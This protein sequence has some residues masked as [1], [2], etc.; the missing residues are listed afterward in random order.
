MTEAVRTIAV[1][2]V[3][4]DGLVLVGRRSPTAVEWPDFDEFPGGKVEPGETTAEAATRECLE[5]SGIAVR[6]GERSFGV[7]STPARPH[8]VVSFH[9]AT[10]VD[11]AATPTPPFAWIPLSQLPKLNFPPANAPVLAMLQRDQG[12]S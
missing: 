3:V 1:A 5:E 7:A 11:P 10:P 12:G 4:Q 8:S 6:V 2:V 9:W